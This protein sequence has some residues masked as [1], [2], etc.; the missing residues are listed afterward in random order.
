MLLMLTMI[1]WVVV[2]VPRESHKFSKKVLEH[3]DIEEL[4]MNYQENKFHSPV[5]V[6]K[7]I[8]FEDNLEINTNGFKLT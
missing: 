1:I 8:N 2:P 6:T 3:C 4:R 5:S 7:T